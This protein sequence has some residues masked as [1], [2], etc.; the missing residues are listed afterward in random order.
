[1]LKAEHKPANAGAHGRLWPGLLALVLACGATCARAD[2][3]E[4]PATAERSPAVRSEFRNL[5]WLTVA[6]H[7]EKT[8]AEVKLCR[9]NKR[10]KGKS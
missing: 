3:N 6:E 2:E 8:R 5:Q 9:T 10:A 7:K 1:M 4:T